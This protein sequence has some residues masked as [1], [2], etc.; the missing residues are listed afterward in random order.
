MLE[1]GDPIED[2][3]KEKD[4][5]QEDAEKL[6]P[7]QGPRQEFTPASL[8]STLHS[9]ANQAKVEDSDRGRRRQ[10]K[11][12]HQGEIFY[13]AHFDEERNFVLIDGRKIK[14][15]RKKEESHLDQEDRQK[16]REGD[17]D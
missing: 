16:E 2:F 7:L 12:Q 1:S 5:G 10:I 11:S 14:R 6:D 17:S 4:N 15:G 8:C 9:V 3:R 13:K